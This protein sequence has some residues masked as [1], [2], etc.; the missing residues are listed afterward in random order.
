MAVKDVNVGDRIRVANG[1]EVLVSEIETN[2]LG[3]GM[4]AFIEDTA[5]RWFKQ[6]MPADGQVEVQRAS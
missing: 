3:A 2:F 1:Q 6:P 4:Y 5:D